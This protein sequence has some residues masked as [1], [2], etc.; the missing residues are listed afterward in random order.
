MRLVQYPKPRPTLHRAE[1]VR[2]LTRVIARAAE[3]NRDPARFPFAVRRLFVFGSFLTDQE[4]LGD[5]DIAAEFKLV[6]PAAELFDERPRWRP[7]HWQERTVV[8]LHVRKPKLVSIHDILEVRT[9]QTPT[10][11]VFEDETID[12]P[13]KPTGDQ[14]GRA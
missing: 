6:R 12:R 4:M 11:L 7:I 5:L 8:A 1:A 9:L 13:P 10:K 14:S 3:I 2:L